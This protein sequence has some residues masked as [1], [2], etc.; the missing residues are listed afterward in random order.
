MPLIPRKHPMIEQPINDSST[1]NQPNG[2]FMDPSPS[3][4]ITYEN[5]S[6]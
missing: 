5:D 4:M 6:S 2:S 1:I 3:R